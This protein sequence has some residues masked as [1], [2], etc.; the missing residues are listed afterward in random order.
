M[1]YPIAGASDFPEERI[2]LLASD[3]P[4]REG[5]ASGGGAFFVG[6]PRR[7]SKKR[8]GVP[9]GS[10]LHQFETFGETPN[11]SEGNG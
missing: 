3:A 9:E 8:A 7:Q 6:G 11:V 1:I 5:A 4:S 10:R 2:P